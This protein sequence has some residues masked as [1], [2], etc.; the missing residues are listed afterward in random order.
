M[1]KN[2]EHS[3]PSN[4]MIDGNMV[5]CVGSKG[6]IDNLASKYQDSKLI[7]LEKKTIQNTGPGRL[8][9]LDQPLTLK[10][11]IEKVKV[12]LELPNLRL[13]KAVGATLGKI[14][15]FIEYSL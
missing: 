9:T 13:A 5:T 7:K 1:N 6:Y 2:Q 15:K 12:H 4:A 3:M 8:L 10:E 14:L 11:A